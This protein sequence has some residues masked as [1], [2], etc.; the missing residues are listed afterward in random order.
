MAAV[1]EYRREVYA[2]QKDVTGQVTSEQL[3]AERRRLEDMRLA[4]GARFTAIDALR[5]LRAPRA[6]VYHIEGLHSPLPRKSANMRNSSS[7]YT[8]K[9]RVKIRE[10]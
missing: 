1:Q 8:E 7:P 10:K 9:D 4:L 3:S 2:L 6:P 5:Y